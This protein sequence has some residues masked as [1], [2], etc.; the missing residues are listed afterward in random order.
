[1]AGDTSGDV[2]TIC[3]SDSGRVSLSLYFQFYIQYLIRRKTR[4]IMLS[5][6]F[7][8]QSTAFRKVTR[9]W[10]SVWAVLCS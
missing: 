8:A 1:M 6:M 3:L 7:L 10:P 5:T 9:Y 2:H 4:I